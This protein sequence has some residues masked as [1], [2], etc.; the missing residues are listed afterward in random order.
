MQI[1]PLNDD[2]APSVREAMAVILLTA[3]DHVPSAWHD[4]GAARDEV[5]TFFGNPERLA[6]GAFDGETLLGWIG[7][8]R[9]ASHAWELHPLVVD[10]GH[11]GSGIGTRLVGTLENEARRAG[12]C[13]L[14]LGTDDDIGGTNIYGKDIYPDVLAHAAAIAPTTVSHPLTFYQRLGFVVTGLLPDA[15][16][17]GRHDIILAKR[18]GA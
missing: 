3:L 11:H 15:T 7:A 8:I 1:G 18:I 10:P 6:F 16:G 13:T 2:T 14:W 12:I 4:I 9:A 17:A 5:A